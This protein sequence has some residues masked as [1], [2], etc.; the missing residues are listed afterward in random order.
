MMKTRY[1]FTTLA[2]MILVSSCLKEEQEM[3]MSETDGLLKVRLSVPEIEVKASS[4]PKCYA[5]LPDELQDGTFNPI[6]QSGTNKDGDVYF[7]AIPEDADEVVFTPLCG[8]ESEVF[9]I[10]T[11]ANGNVTFVVD[12]AATGGSYLFDGEILAG[13]VGNIVPGT[14]EPYDVQIKRLSSKLTT[15]F[16]VKDVGGSTNIDLWT[17]ITSVKVEYSGLGDS[18]SIFDDG[19]ALSSGCQAN[20]IQ[21]V[22]VHSY[23]KCYQYTKD[24]NFIPS[25]EVPF[26]KI[27]IVRNSGL[28]LKY[29]KSL[30]KKLEPNHHYTVNL[31]VRTINSGAS[32]EVDDPEVTV[33]SPVTP[34]VTESEFFTISDEVTL[35][36]EVG[37]EL[38]IDVS[39]VLPYEWDF[40]LDEQAGQYFT[41][42]QVDGKLKVVVKEENSGDIR[43]GNVTLKSKTGGYT[44]TFA[45][46][47]FST[48]KH[49]IIMT[50][51]GSSTSS[52]DIYITG[53]NITVELTGRTS[54]F[55][56]EAKALNVSP[57]SGWSGIYVYNG[58][59]I[60]I[61]G[62]VITEIIVPH[63]SSSGFIV[64][65]N[66]VEYSLISSHN[67]NTY[68]YE[69][70][71]CRNLQTI[72]VVPTNE[73]LDFS[74]MPDLKKIAL[75]ENSTL[76]TITFA[77][78]QMV[79]YLTLY[80]CNNIQQLDL[81]NISNTLSGINLYDC[82]AL[83]GVSL[84]NF[85]DL[86]T[87]CLN[88]C[89]SMASINLSGCT[90]LESF[91]LLNN[92]AKSLNVSGCTSLKS[93]SWNTT[94]DKLIHD[95]AD[96]IESIG[97]GGYVADFNFS[98]MGS[99][100]TIGDVGAAIFDVNNCPSLESIG[101]LSNVT[102]LNV[103]NCPLIK[104]L[105]VSFT[106]SSQTYS[107][108]GCPALETIYF[109]G[110]VSPCDL[111]PLSALKVFHSTNMTGQSISTFDFS[112]N[113]L[114]ED[115]KLSSSNS[116]L[117]SPYWFPLN[118]LILPQSIRSLDIFGMDKLTSL[119][120][121]NYKNLQNLS[122]EQCYS[123]N[124]IDFSGCTSL[125]TLRI[126]KCWYLDYIKFIGCT[127]LK[128]IALEECD[129][130]YDIN[131]SNCSSLETLWMKNVCNTIT[132]G[133]TGKLYLS[134]CSSLVSINR[135]AGDKKNYI[136]YISIFDFAGCKS[137]EHVNIY[138][139]DASSLNFTDSPKLIYL[140]ARNNKLSAATID[141]MFATMPDRNVIDDGAIPG[142]YF[143]SGNSSGWDQYNKDAAM[144]K[145]WYTTE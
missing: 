14:Q 23:N 112:H 30:G 32:F 86:N 141:A 97:G 64:N 36:G 5:Y 136:P 88:E 125:E 57:L 114:L 54:K 142:K 4:A 121:T 73:E 35:A 40:E 68:N 41:V 7:Y 113:T 51:T 25:Q 96:S 11:D 10:T 53:E 99:L 84:K 120:K 90:T 34:D 145:G 74:E 117:A 81:R 85:T 9:D 47:Q 12:T 122:I 71:N 123:L 15:N 67:Y 106:S 95:G 26:V 3:S 45:L 107:F 33:S 91:D 20:E 60:T 44:K 69:F 138:A 92:S 143:L 87:V 65:H 75:G 22:P 48:R 27:T 131:F 129:W 76:T 119:R 59:T 115:L 102:D 13:H 83:I 89:S 98:G 63:L 116:S 52:T 130:L 108:S 70:K 100:K 94:L 21:L 78:G 37:S 56:E 82:D 19:S 50:Y 118:N 31:S 24:T 28:T 111:S 2:M 133:N 43:Y 80:S 135:D 126:V 127:G 93:L 46:R 39:T 101:K 42:E 58:G 38:L 29:T 105:D 137:L 140:D 1:I 104:T 139:A 77:E 16:V 132:L 79:E 8:D 62:D 110:I 109:K 17:Y 55:Y 61:K 103:S 49:E 124:D 72:I 18:V 6:G 128:T 66:G 144:A 134:G